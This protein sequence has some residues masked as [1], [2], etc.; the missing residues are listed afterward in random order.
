MNSEQSLLRNTTVV[1]TKDKATLSEEISATILIEPLPTQT[2]STQNDKKLEPLKIS[3]G[4]SIPK[5]VTAPCKTPR[6]PQESLQQPDPAQVNEHTNVQNKDIVIDGSDT[7]EQERQVIQNK[8]LWTQ[9][10]P[11]MQQ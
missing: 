2:A 1:R 10:P 9:I 11:P 6:K 4:I 8:K 7:L 5:Q 3:Q